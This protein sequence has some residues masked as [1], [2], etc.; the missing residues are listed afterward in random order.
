MALA[1]SS[2]DIHSILY[3]GRSGAGEGPESNELPSGDT[4]FH[5]PSDGMASLQERVTRLEI[6]SLYKSCTRHLIQIYEE[7]QKREIP[8]LIDAVNELLEAS[9]QPKTDI[10]TMPD[11][12]EVEE[13]V[14]KLGCS[15]GQASTLAPQGLDSAA[16]LAVDSQAPF[17]ILRVRDLAIRLK[18]SA[19]WIYAHAEELGGTRVGRSWIFSEESVSNALLGQER[20]LAGD[21]PV[22]RTKIQKSVQNQTTGHRMGGSAPKGAGR[23]TDSEDSD[24]RNRH[25]LAELVQ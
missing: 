25:G 4:S 23:A 14:R 19:K 5:L 1:A 12:F 15:P 17:P 16:E 18:K 7:E 13:A 20:S 9:R 8:E 3:H 6:S 11:G 24:D 22:A 21:R 10:S 2:K